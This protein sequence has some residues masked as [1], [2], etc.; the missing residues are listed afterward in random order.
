M[1]I[2]YTAFISNYVSIFASWMYVC[3]RDGPSN[4]ALAPQPL[5][6]Y[7]LSFIFPSNTTIYQLTQTSVIYFA[8]ASLIEIPPNF[9]L[10]DHCSRMCYG[11]VIEYVRFEVFTAVT[12]KNAVIWDVAPCKSCVN[13]RFGGTYRLHL[14]GRKICELASETSAHTRSARRT[15][16]KTTF[17]P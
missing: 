3:I 14:Q 9:L 13:R 7:I 17:F 5:F 6:I 11:Y 16:K 1:P 10:Q 8:F 4:P 12:V 2:N 15:S